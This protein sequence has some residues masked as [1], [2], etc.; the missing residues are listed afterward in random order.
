MEMAKNRRQDPTGQLLKKIVSMGKDTEKLEPSDIAS[1]GGSN[2]SHCGKC[3]QFLNDH[4]IPFLDLYPRALK[5]LFM[6]VIM[7]D[8]K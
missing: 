6:Y 5:Y 4:A 7:I 2:C 1:G 8:K 3:W